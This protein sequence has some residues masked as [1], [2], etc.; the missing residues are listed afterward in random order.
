MPGWWVA[1]LLQLGVRTSPCSLLG[2]G[3]FQLDPCSS[4]LPEQVLQGIKAVGRAVLGVPG[5]LVEGWEAS[6]AAS[7]WDEWS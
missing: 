4:A 7:V 2:V 1:A 3:A 6:S 5:A